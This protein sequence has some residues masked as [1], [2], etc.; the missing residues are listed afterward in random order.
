MTDEAKKAKRSA[1]VAM[2]DRLIANK[3]F[4]CWLGQILDE[5]CAFEQ[6]FGQVDEFRQGIRAAGSF[7]MDSLKAGAGAP[8]ML[9]KLFA[10][11]IRIK[12]ED[13]S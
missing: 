12:K 11:H 10:D 2:L 3:D 8:Q 1:H 6:G 9:G 13:R 4:T 5:F 7:M